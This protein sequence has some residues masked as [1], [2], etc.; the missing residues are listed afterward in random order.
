MK[1]AKTLTPRTR[2]EVLNL[3][4]DA[5]HHAE[6]IISNMQEFLKMLDERERQLR[7]KTTPWDLAQAQKR[8]EKK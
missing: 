1:K 5:R 2:S 4:A 8:K 3:M 7:T 6:Q